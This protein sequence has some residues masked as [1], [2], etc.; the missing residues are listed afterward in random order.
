MGIL[1]ILLTDSTSTVG[2]HSATTDWSLSTFMPKFD[3]AYF[4]TISMLVF[5]VG[6]CEK[7]SPYVKEVENPNKISLKV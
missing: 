7:I 1:Y 6:G 3:F 4:T 2:A 5:A